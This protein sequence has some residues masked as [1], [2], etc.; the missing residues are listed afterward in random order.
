M[1]LR[2]MAQRGFLAGDGRPVGVPGAMAEPVCLPPVADLLS[3]EVG[4]LTAALAA[5]QAKFQQYIEAADVM[6]QLAAVRKAVE[7]NALPLDV[8]QALEATCRKNRQTRTMAQAVR[9]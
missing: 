9:Q 3:A 7:G 1:K 6:L 5:L 2:E 4:R 8:V